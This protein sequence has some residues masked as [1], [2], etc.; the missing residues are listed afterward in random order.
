MRL[1]ID[2][3]FNKATM[4]YLAAAYG[5]PKARAA[6]ERMSA[7]I[8]RAKQAEDE[9]RI[10]DMW[11]SLVTDSGDEIRAGQLTLAVLYRPVDGGEK[12]PRQR[13]LTTILNP[14]TTPENDRASQAKA[15]A[16]VEG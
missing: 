13:W 16:P 6:R 3:F 10:C 4:N 9:G 7:V 1:G 14:E 12:G 11:P 2:D 5:W 8:A 15:R